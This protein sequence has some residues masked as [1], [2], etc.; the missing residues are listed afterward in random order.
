M[1]DKDLLAEPSPN[2]GTIVQV[3]VQCLKPVIGRTPGAERER[4]RERERDRE[5]E[6]ERSST[7]MTTDRQEKGRKKPLTDRQFLMKT[8]KNT[9]IALM[10]RT[11]KMFH[12]L[13]CKYD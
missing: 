4:E 6:R 7:Q 9:A 2:P 10:T 1:A 12:S 5:T 13:K 11:H 3:G 8:A